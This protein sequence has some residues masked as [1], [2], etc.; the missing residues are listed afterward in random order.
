M[1]TL[2]VFWKA[3]FV[4]AW[5]LVAGAAIMLAL[6]A[7]QG[8]ALALAWNT[9]IAPAL[10]LTTSMDTIQGMLVWVAVGVLRRDMFGKPNQ[11]TVRNSLRS[12][13]TPEWPPRN[14][15]TKTRP[16][17]GAVNPTANFEE[18]LKRARAN[19]AENARKR[20]G[21]SGNGA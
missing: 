18:A 20:T 5:G 9:A 7:V 16:A 12:Q 3:L 8:W 21:S 11:V 4:Q 2:Q 19:A 6:V 14:L 1:K 13:A 15:Q 17:P 10:S